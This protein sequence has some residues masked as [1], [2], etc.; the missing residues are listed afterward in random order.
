MLKASQVDVN[1]NRIADVSGKCN[2]VFRYRY[3]KIDHL[4]FEIFDGQ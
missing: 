3:T 4:M 2:P 1:V